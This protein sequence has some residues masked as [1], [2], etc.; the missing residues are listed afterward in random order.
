MLVHRP[1]RFWRGANG[2]RDRHNWRATQSRRPL[3][4]NSDAAELSNPTSWSAGDMVWRRDQ[5]AHDEHH[6]V[7]QRPDEVHLQSRPSG[8]GNSIRYRGLSADSMLTRWKTSVHQARRQWPHHWGAIVG[9]F[10][11]AVVIIVREGLEAL[12]LVTALIAYA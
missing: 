9:T 5:H 12:M 1:K 6:A 11:Q 7:R 4:S 10:L 2:R 3:R 8:F